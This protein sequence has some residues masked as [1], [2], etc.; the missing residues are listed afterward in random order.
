[1]EKVFGA[2]NVTRQGSF[3]QYCAAGEDEVILTSSIIKSNNLFLDLF[4]TNESIR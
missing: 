3:A 2:L 1:L 4:K